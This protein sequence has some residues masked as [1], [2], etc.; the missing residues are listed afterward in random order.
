[1]HRRHEYLYKTESKQMQPH[2]R[3][4]HTPRDQR[5]RGEPTEMPSGGRASARDGPNSTECRTAWSRHSA[6]RRGLPL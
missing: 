5:T 2:T 4:T 3:V 1:M 6:C